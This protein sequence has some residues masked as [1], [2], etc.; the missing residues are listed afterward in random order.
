M[1]QRVLGKWPN[2]Y[3]GCGDG[4]DRLEIG[5]HRPNPL[6]RFNVY[7][8]PPIAIGLRDSFELIQGVEGAVI[9]FKHLAMNSF[10][11]SRR[12]DEPG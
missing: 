10:S 3:L 9:Y 4:L 6:R 7:K 1:L 12:I 11:F 8:A 2:S 5:K